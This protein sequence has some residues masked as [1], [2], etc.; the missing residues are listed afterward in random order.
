MTAA[1]VSEAEFAGTPPSDRAQWLRPSQVPA[2]SE[3]LFTPRDFTV[4]ELPGHPQ[5]MGLI[6]RYDAVRAAL[7]NPNALRRSV[8]FEY[9]PAEHRHRTLY[10]SWAQD[11]EQRRKLRRT[12]T[13][14][15]RGST[16]QARRFTRELT[17]ELLARLLNED[18]PWDLVRVISTVSMRV[19]LEQTLQAPPL[20]RHARRLRELAREHSVAAGGFFGI[21]RQREA[22]QILGSITGRYDELPAGGLAHHLVGLYQT[23]QLDLDSLQGQ[24]WLLIVSTESQAA[25]VA[26]L[27]GTI[28][29]FDEGPYAR[30]ILGD[31]DAMQRLVAEGLRMGIVFPAKIATAAQ[32]VDLDGQNLHAGSPCWI[33]FAAANRDPAAFD[34]PDVFD[35]R[36]KRELPHLSFG[37]GDGRCQGEVG[38]EQFVE[39]VLTSVLEGLP[40]GTQ[41]HNGLLQRETGINMS[42]AT[43]PAIPAA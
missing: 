4:M 42:V 31:R 22:E 33:C 16:E 35:P 18:A 14:V 29:E 12:L 37:T 30:S 24:L 28:C 15:N 10:A 20:I 5:P 7:L 25:A 13:R 2:G 17:A 38:A 23:D 39:D 40:P 41:L 32:D 34:R 9:L 27:L 36:V 3:Y 11:G 6:T 26:S 1:V 8:P 21:T 43:L 19:M